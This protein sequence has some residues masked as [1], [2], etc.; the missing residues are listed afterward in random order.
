MTI[1]YYRD[2]NF[3]HWD[4]SD[5][6]MKN[7]LFWVSGAAC[8]LGTTATLP[9]Q[10][11]MFTLSGETSVQTSLSTTF[12]PSPITSD[13]VYTIAP[14]Q[15]D[16]ASLGLSDAEIV[17]ALDDPEATFAALSND[18]L[19]SLS[20]LPNEFDVLF[21]APSDDLSV[22]ADLIADFLPATV[23]GIDLTEFTDYID[24]F[25]AF[26]PQS[27]ISAGLTVTGAI[28]TT[29]A[30]LTDYSFTLDSTTGA[31]TFA[32]NMPE[33]LEI[34]L[35]DFCQLT[36][37]F[38]AFTD[39]LISAPVLGSVPIANAT[40]DGSFRLA[41]TPVLASGDLPNPPTVP[42]PGVP[43]SPSIPAPPAPPVVPAPP[44]SPEIPV[45]SDPPE[46]TPVP[47]PMSAIAL[48]VVLAGGLTLTRQSPQG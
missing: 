28:A 19:L 39:V 18:R 25:S 7:R 46:T 4:Y 11:Y 41:S 32:A 45:I 21:D 3:I 30:A 48:V 15:V 26:L 22:Y 33:N 38:N 29:T 12:S 36:G 31:F 6:I 9:A 43:A 47:E 23:G 16:T 2:F 5:F 24:A 8:L 20:F 35:T 37:N 1:D 10:A 14:V 44:I 17:A 27:D 40:L 13:L 34:C 42:T